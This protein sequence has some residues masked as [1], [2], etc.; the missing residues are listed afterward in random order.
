MTIDLTIESRSNLKFGVRFQRILYDQTICD[1]KIIKAFI[2]I[3]PAAK[4]EL[5]ALTTPRECQSMIDFTIPNF[6]INGICDGFLL[7][8][9]NLRKENVVI[10]KR[11][12]KN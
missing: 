5:I 7:L 12:F 10:Y 4:L 3:C 1:G 6:P 9:P 2:I 11:F 8:F